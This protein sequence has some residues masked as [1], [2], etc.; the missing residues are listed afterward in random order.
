MV[1]GVFTAL[2]G[3][4]LR[5]TGDTLVGLIDQNSAPY[6]NY[7][8]IAQ[9]GSNLLFALGALLV[10]IGVLHSIY[11]SFKKDRRKNEERT[12]AER[13]EDRRE[14]SREPRE[15]RPRDRQERR[16]R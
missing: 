7:A 5:Y 2:L 9:I 13:R 8:D 3:A 12:E 4:V 11:L 6:F 14:E 10:V 16:R 1:L 15:T